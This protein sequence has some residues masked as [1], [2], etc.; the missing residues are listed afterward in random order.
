MSIPRVPAAADVRYT[1]AIGSMRVPRYSG[2]M[3]RVHPRRR[4]ASS[5]RMRGRYTSRLSGTA[6]GGRHRRFRLTPEFFRLAIE[7]LSEYALITLDRELRISSW[8]GPARAMFG[9]EEADIIGRDVATIFT[10]EDIARGIHRSEF[11]KALEKGREDD[12][13]WHVRKDGRRLWCYGLSFPLRDSKGGVRGFVKIIRDDS[14][15]KEKDD[16]LEESEERLRLA[17]ES[18]G[19]GTWDYDVRRR[20]LHLSDRAAELFGLV[21]GPRD[22]GF[23]Q[24]VERVHEEDRERIS[25]DF[26]R[27]IGGGQACRS[28]L[29]Y[30]VRMPGGEVRWVR[31]LARAFHGEPESQHPARLL[32]TVVDITAARRRQAGAEELNRELERRV[33]ERTAR[34]TALNRELETFAY[35]ASHDLRA[36][37]RKIAVF[38]QAILQSGA[39]R[40]A[41]EDQARFERIRVAASRMNRLIDDM[42]DL[43]RV[44]RKPLEPADCDL[45]AAARAVAAELQASDPARRVEFAIAGG[46]RAQGDRE[47]LTIALRNLLENA[48]KFTSRHPRARIEFGVRS[49]QGRLVYFVKDDGAGFDMSHAQALF[50]AFRRLHRE[51]E[52]AGTGVGLGMVERI[53][54]RHRGRVWAE[55]Q[56][57]KGA[58]FF[59]TLF[60]EDE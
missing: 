18:T 55:A 5:S 22:A 45:S 59:F 36:P 28:D 27:C 39:S 8:S 34:L 58:T 52:F 3:A 53:V 6:V 11:Q 54:R 12:E 14:E 40:L 51:D 24:F 10:P 30:R 48:W 32:G 56:V 17:A 19:L 46:V 26:E 13:R 35:S 20:T 37:L 47:L 38:S 57:E 23:D 42:L 41:P 9:Y 43:S 25:R 7:S 16:R 33:K 15:R 44:T 31:T 50:G 1:D 60:T 2:G 29:E 21:P 49:E 4:G